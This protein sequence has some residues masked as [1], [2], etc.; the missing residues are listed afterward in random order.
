MVAI[1]EILLC[2]IA[3]LLAILSLEAKDLIHG[4]LILAAFTVVIGV[5]Y[6]L[7]GST[8]VAVFQISVYAA[9]MTIL[10]IAVVFMVRR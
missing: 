8:Y 3:V 5:L 7:M 6:F 2:I 1:I 9:A 10:F 4:V